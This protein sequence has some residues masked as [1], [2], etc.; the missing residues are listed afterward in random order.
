MR[1]LYLFA[2]AGLMVLGATMQVQAK[3][4][5]L[6]DLTESYDIQD[7]D[8]LTGKLASS[9][10]I[11]ASES[12][13]F[14]LLDA[15]INGDGSL[16]EYYAAI[17]IEYGDVT[18]LLRGKNKL[19]GL[20][21]GEPGIF[22]HA[23][24]SLTID[25]DGELTVTGRDYAAGIG[26]GTGANCKDPAGNILIKG[27]SITA[28][29]GI[30]AAA[31]GSGK[32]KS[33]GSITV[34]GTTILLDATPGTGAPC[35]IGA[36]VDG[37]CGTVTV[38]GE[39]Y[40][41]GVAYSYYY[42]RYKSY[43]ADGIYYK[44]D[45][46]TNEATVVENPTKYTGDII[47]P[48]K[49]DYADGFTVTKI[50]AYAF[51]GCDVTSVTLPS[52][53]QRIGQFAFGQCKEL[54]SLTIP[55]S[56]TVLSGNYIFYSNPKLEAINVEEEN[57]NYCSV[58]GV[59]FTKDKKIL[60]RYP[61]ARK[62]AEYSIPDGVETLSE[63]ALHKCLQLTS[64]V[65]PASVT[66]LGRLS[67]MCA[68]LTELTCYAVTPPS[69]TDNVFGGVSTSIPVN[70]PYGCTAA[71][72][73][74]EKWKAFT[75]YVEMPIPNPVLIDGIN[76]NLDDVTR[77]ASVQ[78]L[79]KGKY[80]GDIVIPDKVTYHGVEFDV[81]EIG[82]YAFQECY[83]VTSITL[84]EGLNI[85]HP[86]AFSKTAIETITIP[87]SV[88]EIHS[89]AFA[90][91]FYLTAINVEAANSYYCSVDGVLF[92]KDMKILHSY[93]INKAV[94]EYSIPDGVEEIYPG[95]FIYAIN[96]TGI[97]FP[98][99]VNTFGEFCFEECGSLKYIISLIT[100]PSDATDCFDDVPKD[101][102][103]FV[104]KDHIADYNVEGWKDFTNYVG[105]PLDDQVIDGINYG[106]DLMKR[107]ATV[108]ALPGSDKY[109]G[110]LEIPAQ[111]SYLGIDFAVTTIGEW[112][113]SNCWHLTSVSLP[114]SLTTIE[115]GAFSIVGL[116]SITIPAS[117]TTIAPQS[118]TGI[119]IT[120]IEV[121][122]A[123]ANYASVDGVLFNKAKTKLIQYPR[124][125]EG[126]YEIPDG[127]EIIGVD[128]LSNAENLT[129][130]R[131][132]SSVTTIEPAALLMCTA[133]RQVFSRP[134]TTPTLGA[135][136]F[137]GIDLDKV[138]LVVTPGN[139]G[140]Y[141]AAPGWK[142]FSHVM[143]LEAEMTIDGI[144]YTLDGVNLTAILE[145]L[146]DPD[147]Y[148]GEIEIPEFVTWAADFTVKTIG[149]K[150]FA[151]CPELTGVSIPKGVENIISGAFAG[152]PKLEW[153]EVDDDNTH[154]K[155]LKNKLL[156]NTD[157][158]TIYAACPAAL[159]G[160]VNL[161][162]DFERIEDWAFYGC[163]K[164]TSIAFPASLLYIGDD[165]FENCTALAKISCRATTPPTIGGTD[166]FKG[167][168]KSIPVYVPKA[169]IA[170][171]KA[172]DEWKDFTN[173]IALED[174]EAAGDVIGKIDAIG[175][176][177]YTDACHDKITAAREAYDKLTADQKALI[178]DE[179]YKVLT[180]AEAKYAELKAAA[181]KAAADKAAADAVIGKIDAI[182]TVEYTDACHDKITAAREAYDK[183]T[184]DQKALIS[185]AKY[186]VL[187]DAEAK[188]E[189]L[190]AQAEGDK[191][192]ADL[193]IGKIDAIGTVEYTDACHDKI[194]AARTAYD[195][196]TAD[197]KALISD[198]KYKVLT[199]AEAKYAELVEE[200][201]AAAELAKAKEE[202]NA[203]I[204]ELEVLKNFAHD[205]GLTEIEASLGFSITTA[206][207]VA[208]NEGATIEQ[209]QGATTVAQNTLSSAEDSLLTIA[210]TRFK[211]ELDKLLKPEDSD[212]CKQI[213][214]DAK[215][216][217]DAITID[218]EKSA[219]EN[220]AAV[221]KA[222]EDIL[223]KAKADLEAQRKSEETPTGLDQV[224]QPYMAGQKVL[225]NG[226][227]FILIGDKMYDATG[228]LVK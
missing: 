56:V 143:E 163:E 33:V 147:K 194:T 172:E 140:A 144:R 104:P 224:E 219:A 117:V 220:I 212:A 27:G 13:T 167:V 110:E 138:L 108:K 89:H 198:E 101:I 64:V 57:A 173:Y 92:T 74:V 155:S 169:S 171:Y 159:E 170:S 161:A 99:T 130:L 202:L 160:P 184:E 18:M 134:A 8:T 60:I 90:S 95:A 177:E 43:D 39:V 24:A 127:V 156:C 228:K 49:V 200:A 175:T 197:Q 119:Y 137:D 96:L 225:I 76:Y 35:S 226:K 213:I 87:A 72:K 120:S 123:N 9:V 102:P 210:K 182:G 53:L 31:I 115:M 135:D 85:I 71:Y 180:D 12:L 185:D 1:K 124:G 44:L 125:R 67:M 181:E 34:E 21:F 78:P 37:S 214:A 38:R 154:F 176:V 52:T 55:A 215:D 91:C 139:A 209:V 40:P 7:G 114:S 54:T 190:K 128:A 129:A 121:E 204:A 152:S 136:V 63:E 189:V 150:A 205:N 223:N 46:A 164:I 187:T 133:L 211:A 83:D 97:T 86:F 15:D 26:N 69:P 203:V 6:A 11:S 146:P 22:V 168:D 112:A 10:F 188:Y 106:L 107:E 192:A 158:T 82:V 4:V 216:D 195:A 162:S 199:D 186:K 103:V 36:G 166:V 151:N 221:Q 45:W 93:P 32:G 227:M 58:D 41:T 68:N 80:T 131:I 14:T 178:S 66:E 193:V 5:N 141:T 179:K 122:E 77:T 59:L 20:H 3:V 88:S 207:G 118:L 196:L 149:Y 113:F 153:I 174:D 17:G 25:G 73:A 29:G 50:G 142:D 23:P 165:A 65:I 206:K 132:P 94:T 105:L 183:L 116:S 75:N 218:K 70:I 100:T 81:R 16:D 61:E 48:E 126:K 28:I 191:A 84:P 47:I 208:D 111:V 2:L 222:G 79:S 62:A 145:P 30:N 109:E 51:D 217:V 201:K 42:S 19:Q 157:I 98:S 148:E